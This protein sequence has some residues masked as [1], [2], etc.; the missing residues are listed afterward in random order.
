[1]EVEGALSQ[2][3]VDNLHRSKKKQKQGVVKDFSGVSVVKETQLLGEQASVSSRPD[4]CRGSLINS[5]ANNGDDDSEYHSD[6][7]AD[8]EDSDSEEEFLSTLDPLCPVV[9]L[10]K[11]ELKNLSIPWKRAVIVKLLGKKVGLKMLPNRLA[12]LWQPKSFMDIIYLENDYFLP[13]PVTPSVQ[14]LRKQRRAVSPSV[15]PS[16]Q[17]SA[18]AVQPFRSRSA[19]AFRSSVAPSAPPFRSHRNVQQRQVLRSV[20]IYSVAAPEQLRQLRST[21]FS[22]SVAAPLSSSVAAPLSSSDLLRSQLRFAAP[23]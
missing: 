20:P 5:G 3:E 13:P 10:S 11:K 17:Q 1:M 8:E 18:R 6:S 12:K 9:K 23:T 4:I 22:N 19:A 16:V 21:L 2:E 7:K 14:S 15:G